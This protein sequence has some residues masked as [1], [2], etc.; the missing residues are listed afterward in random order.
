MLE[1]ESAYRK[2]GNT[3]F[4]SI[5][6]TDPFDWW[7]GRFYVGLWGVVAILAIGAGVGVLF[8]AVG[9]YGDWDLWRA[10]VHAP[11]RQYGLGVAPF[12]D[13]GAWQAVVVLATLAF[14]SW[15][16]R[17]VDICRKLEMGYHIPLMFSFA[18]SAWVTLQIIRPLW[19]GC[20]CEGFDL[21]YSGHLTWVSNTGFRYQNFYLN[22]FHAYAILGFFLT[23]MA[24]AMHGGVRIE[25]PVTHQ[26]LA[27]MIGTA[28]E[29]VSRNMARFRQQGYVKDGHAATLEILNLDSLEALIV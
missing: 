13:G 24:L 18:I 22:P 16:L 2:P 21:S 3:L 19:M 25:L 23:A 12:L 29:T 14:V 6:G 7:A 5:L 27:N 20:W 17:E 28:R 10:N 1:F 9:Q 4:R 26:D 15:A 8:I 11:L